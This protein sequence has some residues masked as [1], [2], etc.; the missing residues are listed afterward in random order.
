MLSFP[1]LRPGKP[2][3]K[4]FLCFNGHTHVPRTFIRHE[5]SIHEYESGDIQLLKTNK[6]LINV[7]SVGQPRDGVPLVIMSAYHFKVL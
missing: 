4:A 7:G 2:L 5:G 6:Y 3:Q 1:A